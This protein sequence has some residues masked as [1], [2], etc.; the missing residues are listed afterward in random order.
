MLI[1]RNSNREII[2]KLELKKPKDELSSMD[3][4]LYQNDEER[5]N[6]I[7]EISNE[8]MVSNIYQKIS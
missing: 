8:L 7:F 2:L 6:L 5:Y 3:R 1:E 4:P